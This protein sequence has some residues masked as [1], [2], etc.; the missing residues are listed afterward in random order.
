M[1]QINLPVNVDDTRQGGSFRDL[2]VATLSLDPSNGNEP[3]K[4]WQIDLMKK[5]EKAAQ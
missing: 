1:K 2:F 3:E 4:N 5:N